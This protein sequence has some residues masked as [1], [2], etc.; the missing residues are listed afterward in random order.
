MSLIPVTGRGSTCMTALRSIGLSQRRPESVKSPN[1][2]RKFM[3]SSLRLGMV[4]TQVE[5]VDGPHQMFYMYHLSFIFNK[6]SCVILDLWLEGTGDP[7]FEFGSMFKGAGAATARKEA[8]SSLAATVGPNMDSKYGQ[9]RW[10][11]C[12]FKTQQVNII[13]VCIGYQAHCPC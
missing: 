3:K 13:V 7:K 8:E 10:V 4:S 11:N 1:H 12:I 5:K 6:V 2:T 9:V